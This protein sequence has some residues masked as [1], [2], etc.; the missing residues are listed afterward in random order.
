MQLLKG[1]GSKPSLLIQWRP[2]SALKHQ[3]SLSSLPSSS[4][5][6]QLSVTFENERPATVS[7]CSSRVSKAL[8]LRGDLFIN[9]TGY[10]RS[11]LQTLSRQFKI[12]VLR[13]TIF[14]RFCLINSPELLIHVNTFSSVFVFR[15]HMDRT[16]LTFDFW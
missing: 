2:M 4:K 15:C 3:S 1:S 10:N 7:R 14:M 16:L 13:F 12:Q 9:G 8:S 11:D 5:S 6:S